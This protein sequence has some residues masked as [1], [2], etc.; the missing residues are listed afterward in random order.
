VASRERLPGRGAQ[1]IIEET[2][3]NRTATV[4]TVFGLLVAGTFAL[5]SFADEGQEVK[6]TLEQVPPAVRATIERE[7]AGARIT[8]IELETR[9]GNS[10]YEAEFIQD[11]HEVE[12]RIAPDGTLLGRETEDPDDDEDDLKIADVPEPARSA[13]LKLAAGATITGVERERVAQVVVYGA[14]WTV[15]DVQHEAEVTADGT[16]V[17]LEETVPMDTLPPAVQKAVDKHFAGKAGLVVERKMIVVFEIEAKQNGR[18]REL[19]V[20]PTGRVIAD[21]D[22]DGD[23]DDGDDDDDDDDD[24]DAHAAR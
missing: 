20:L 24:G 12:I 11:G 3:M 17:E 9:N 23:H 21:A 10:V 19:L 7:A 13:L 4:A 2:L 22:D 14:A 6:L 15:N 18:E 16:L 1:Q 8:E 5:G